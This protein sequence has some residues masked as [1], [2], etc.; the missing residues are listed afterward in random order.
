MGRQR[1]RELVSWFV[2]GGSAAAVRVI[3][4]NDLLLVDAYCSDEACWR[5][6]MASM[7]TWTAR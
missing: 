6:A 4:A 2:F 7:T 1:V 3:N 5:V